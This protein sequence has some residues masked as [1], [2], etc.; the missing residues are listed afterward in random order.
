[1][2]FNT[3]RVITGPLVPSS[4]ENWQRRLNNVTETGNAQMLSKTNKIHMWKWWFST[5]LLNSV[6]WCAGVCP[7]CGAALWHPDPAGVAVY[8]GRTILSPTGGH[9]APCR[10]RS[11]MQWFRA[12]QEENNVSLKVKCVKSGRFWRNSHTKWLHV[13][14]SVFHFSSPSWAASELQWPCATK[15]GYLIE[16][17]SSLVRI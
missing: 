6:P 4:S 11:E 12:K 10:S 17:S 7:G 14:R 15:P 9:W 5:S 13:D 8:A 1:M 2:S 3:Q 16:P